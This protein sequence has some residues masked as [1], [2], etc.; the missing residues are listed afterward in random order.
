[1]RASTGG[2]THFTPRSLCPSHLP[3]CPTSH[4]HSVARCLGTRKWYL[5]HAG[6]EAIGCPVLRNACLQTFMSVTL[7]QIHIVTRINVNRRIT[8]T[9][10]RIEEQDQK[11]AFC[12]CDSYIHAYIKIRITDIHTCQDQRLLLYVSCTLTSYIQVSG[13]K[14]ENHNEGPWGNGQRRVDYTVWAPE[15]RERSQQAQR[16]PS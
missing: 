8:D 5:G 3:T 14:V 10:I 4:I 7:V 15:G 2:S 16:V 12:V 6:R 9:S 13:P 11:Y 1:M